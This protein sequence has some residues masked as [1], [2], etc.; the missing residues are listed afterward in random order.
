MSNTRLVCLIDHEK[1]EGTVHH[2][3]LATIKSVTWAP[4]SRTS[5]KLLSLML[6][7]LPLACG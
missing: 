6:L 5:G 3:P 4:Q 2:F 7:V 1:D